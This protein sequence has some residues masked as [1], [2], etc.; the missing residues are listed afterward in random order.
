MEWDEL[1]FMDRE[2]ILEQQGEEDQAKV[3][4]NVKNRGIIDS[5]KRETETA[6]KAEGKPKSKRIE[7]M[8][9]NRRNQLEQERRATPLLPE[10]DNIPARK[11][12]KTVSQTPES[13]NKSVSRPSRIKLIQEADEEE[14]NENK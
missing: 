9:E 5:A 12:T 2:Q 14:Y 8:E 7:S 3:A 10:P 13:D 4:V 6:I 1:A 11:N